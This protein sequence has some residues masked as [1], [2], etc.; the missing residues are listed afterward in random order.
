MW[1]CS[2]CLKYSVTMHAIPVFVSN[3]TSNV[4]LILA[5]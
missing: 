2:A 3:L 1:K 4:C 5:I